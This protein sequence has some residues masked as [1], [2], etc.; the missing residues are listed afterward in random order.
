MA[1][2]G[3]NIVKIVF[4]H[5]PFNI[6]N[7]KI[8]GLNKKYSFRHKDGTVTV[9]LAY[10]SKEAWDQLKLMTSSDGFTAVP[11]PTES[12]LERAK[13]LYL[14]D[15][16]IVSLFGGNDTVKGIPYENTDGDIFVECIKERRFIVSSNGNW[17]YF[18]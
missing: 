15:D 2:H 18:Q 1:I 5:Q 6:L 17:A 7:M 3:A 4:I 16:K 8:S 11:D 12:N 13:R 9:I 10:N 14:I